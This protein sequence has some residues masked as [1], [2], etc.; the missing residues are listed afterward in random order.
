MCLVH[1]RLQ[2]QK[3]NNR[4]DSQQ[5]PNGT[6]ESVAKLSLE[7]RSRVQEALQFQAGHFA[8]LDDREREVRCCYLSPTQYP[9]QKAFLCAG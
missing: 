9:S 6:F 3:S 5:T 4:V 1:L 8:S 7:E 2:C